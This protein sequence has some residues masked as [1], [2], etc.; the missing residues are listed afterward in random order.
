MN[1]TRPD[2]INLVDH[3]NPRKNLSGFTLIELVVVLFVLAVLAA[4][5]LPATRR[6]R[7]AAQR[8]QCRNNLKQIGLALYNY[9][10]DYGAFPPAYTVDANGKPLHSWRTLI[11]PYLDQQALYKKND[12]SKP[13]D[14]PANAEALQTNLP[15]FSCPSSTAPQGKTTYL[16]IVTPDSCLQP[17]QSRMTSEVKDGLSNTLVVV[18]VAPEDAVP[19][20]APQDADLTLLLK[21]NEK[22][23]DA[24]TGGRHGLIGDGTVRFLSNQ[25][26]REQWRALISIKGNESVGEF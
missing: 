19:W 10:S 5:L 26:S 16:A 22:T 7:P 8:T 4:L 18:E 12:L 15:V 11:L 1:P 25:L 23:K 14:D 3:L 24:H 20:M 17:G 2:R 13:W 21:Y 9:E 6:A